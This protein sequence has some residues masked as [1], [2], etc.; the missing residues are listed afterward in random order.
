MRDIHDTAVKFGDQQS[1]DSRRQTL[2]WI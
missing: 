1:S 2:F